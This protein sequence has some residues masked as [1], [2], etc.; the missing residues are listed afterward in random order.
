[1]AD[2]TATQ[3][4][5]PRRAH[6][7]DLAILRRLI[8]A[9][10]LLPAVPAGAIIG[11]HCCD[12]WFNTPLDTVRWINLLMAGFWVAATV[13]IWRAVIIWTLGRTALTAL[14]GM[15]P[16]VQVIV[17]QPLWNA[18]CISNDILRLSQAQVGIGV[19]IWVAVWVWWGW[20]RTRPLGPAVNAVWRYT[21]TPR[22]K[23]TV[24]S[25]GTIPFLVGVFFI[26]GTLFQD[27]I[28]LADRFFTPA[29]YAVSAA[30]AVVVWLLIWRREI[31]WRPGIGTR[32]VL[33]G[34]VTLGL[35]IAATFLIPDV[36][37][38]LDTT[39]RFL[40]L[41]GWGVWMAA[42]IWVWPLRPV[43][44]SHDDAR[45]PRC[46]QCTYSLTGLR[47]TR[48][49]ECGHEPTLDELWAATANPGI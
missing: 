17:G 26:V 16:F 18:G 34:A 29:T 24:A 1:M 42:T 45:Q 23:R 8:C 14:V 7:S 31:V 47:A 21:M 46:P 33:C 19:W 9:L 5:R 38:V 3:E 6:R 2:I 28:G 15:I 41:I 37:G 40:P 10:A 27:L 12:L 13:V 43:S 25:L 48:C 35:P 49:P 11:A 4:T 36:S 32:T 30:V 39:V 44:G 22:A 20:E